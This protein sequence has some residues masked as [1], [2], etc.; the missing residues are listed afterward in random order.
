MRWNIRKF[1]MGEAFLSL[2]NPGQNSHQSYDSISA[3]SASTNIFDNLMPRKPA[4]QEHLD[5]DRETGNSRVSW[6]WRGE[7]L[8]FCLSTTAR[9]YQPVKLTTVLK[10]YDT[11]AWYHFHLTTL[12]FSESSTD[13]PLASRLYPSKFRFSP[14]SYSY[15]AF[16]DIRFRA[17]QWH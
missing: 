10:V 13:L 8:G 5:I 12:F 3:S 17:Q 2:L 6:Q 11:K 15:R 7:A 1:D 4:T 16:R 14:L 9:T